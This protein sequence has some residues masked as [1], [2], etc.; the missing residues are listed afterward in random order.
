MCK[1]S[2]IRCSAWKEFYKFSFD[3]KKHEYWLEGERLLSITEVL[4]PLNSYHKIP[5]DVLNHKT[6]LGTE[7]HHIIHLYIKDNLMEDSIDER[8]LAPFLAFKERV[9]PLIYSKREGGRALVEQPMYDKKLK[10]A[11]TADLI[12]PHD[13]YEWKLRP[14]MP[15]VDV[16]QLAMYDKLAGVRKRR[17]WV[18]SFGLDGSYRQHRAENR[19]AVPMFLMMLKHRREADIYRQSLEDW[20][21]LLK[22]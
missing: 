6:E 13:I 1:L 17:R 9:W 12:L 14:Y 8:L 5:Q 20:K 18:I 2:E 22:E 15:F 4:A 3:K 21:K 16:I 10:V 11:G 7:F 19:Q